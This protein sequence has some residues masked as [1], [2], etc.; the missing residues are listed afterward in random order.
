[1]IALPLNRG[2]DSRDLAGA[3]FVVGFIRAD[4]GTREEHTVSF[5][6]P[7]LSLYVPPAR[8]FP[9]NVTALDQDWAA[10]VLRG[11]SME[12][13]LADAERIDTRP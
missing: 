7:S 8:A 2:N 9:P 3:P 13:V 12:Q 11:R 5:F 1:M 10:D 6:S 4:Y